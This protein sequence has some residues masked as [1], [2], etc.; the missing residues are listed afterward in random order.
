M[1]RSDSDS[2]LQLSRSTTSIR[3]SL[4]IGKRRRG[5]KTDP[6]L[7]W[8]TISARFLR[9]TVEAES[10]SVHENTAAQ[11][12]SF[13]VLRRKNSSFCSSVIS[14]DDS[15]ESFA[16]CAARKP[17]GTERISRRSWKGS[18]S[19]SFCHA[20][21]KLL[22]CFG[23]IC[24]ACHPIK[25]SWSHPRYGKPDTGASFS[26]VSKNAGSQTFQSNLPII[27]FAYS[28]G[29]STRASQKSLRLA[30]KPTRPSACEGFT[31][32]ALARSS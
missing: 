17:L 11:S 15:K 12:V 1:R 25:T 20:S 16:C 27:V 30:I 29:A 5:E 14:G 9:L 8:I 2:R 22:Y 24:S 7:H 19:K 13:P 18:S 28:A 10:W 3:F 6:R 23:S 31:K 26:I 32:Y 21:S 4:R